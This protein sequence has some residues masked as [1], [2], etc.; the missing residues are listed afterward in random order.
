MEENL[1]ICIWKKVLLNDMNGN[2]T[3]FIDRVSGEGRTQD[4]LHCFECDGTK[5]YAQ[6]IDCNKYVAK[7]T[8]S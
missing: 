6:R 3:T 7:K 5:V 1:E 8:V 4:N 2:G